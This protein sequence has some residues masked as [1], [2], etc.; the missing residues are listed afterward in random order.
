MFK[1][2]ISVTSTEKRR[3][4]KKEKDVEISATANITG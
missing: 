1:N 3:C 4:I 2:F